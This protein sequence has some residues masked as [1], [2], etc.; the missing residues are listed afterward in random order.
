MYLKTAFLFLFLI[1]IWACSSSET[2]TD[3]DRTPTETDARILKL[4]TDANWPYYYW[5]AGEQVDTIYGV[6]LDLQLLDE[7][8]NDIKTVTFR[9]PNS[10]EHN[11]E[12]DNIEEDEVYRV[13]VGKYLLT[14]EYS[15]A[16]GSYLYEIKSKKE[17]D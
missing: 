16:R 6:M 7:S 13:V 1:G 15:T 14:G 10:R 5:E 2:Y 12:F 17:E 11:I 3:L 4:N 9:F 8:G